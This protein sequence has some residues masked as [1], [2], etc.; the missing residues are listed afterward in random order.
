[1]GVRE[2][3]PGFIDRS[4]M[5]ESF[6]CLKKYIWNRQDWPEPDD[7]NHFN[8][9]QNQQIFTRSG[10]LIR[11]VPQ[12]PGKQG[13]EQKYESRIYLTGQV[14]TRAGNWHDFFNALV[15]KVFPHAKSVLNELHFQA[16]LAELSDKD[17]NRCGL[18]DAATLFDESG[19]V[20]LSSKFSLIQLIKNFEWKELFWRQRSAVLSSMRFFIFGHGLYEKVLDPYTGMTGKAII[21][22]VKQTFFTQALPVQLA[23]IDLMLEPF[24]LHTLSSSSDLAPVPLLG[25]PGWIEDNN[26]EIYYENKKYFRERHKLNPMI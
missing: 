23:A 21:F 13:F 24:L 8:F 3:D 1:M 19:V 12:I 5:F 17:K 14:P 4:P 15:W 26:D 6:L 18:R 2:W 20:V 22:E 9:Q 11:F 10:K 16:Q 7:L 25:Y